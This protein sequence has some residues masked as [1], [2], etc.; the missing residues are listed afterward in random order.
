MSLMDTVVPSIRPESAATDALAQLALPDAQYQA[1]VD[2]AKAA[3]PEAPHRQALDEYLADT[4]SGNPAFE[5][6]LKRSLVHYAPE[7]A[8]KGLAF[9]L[10]ALK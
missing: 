10:S 7:E 3:L 6:L 2:Q 8:R 4:A 5:D 9:V 1:C